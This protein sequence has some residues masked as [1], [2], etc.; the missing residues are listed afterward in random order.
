MDVKITEITPSPSGE[1]VFVKMRVS[2]GFSAGYAKGEIA[3]DFF[4]SLGLPT[5]I[6]E[7]I[8][9]DEEFYGR[10]EYAM[11]KT[12]AVKMGI[13]LLSFSQNTARSLSQKLTQRGV[14]KEIADDA[15]EYL[16]DC[17]YINEY[18]MA[19]ALIED[20]AKRRYFGKM[21]IKAD[22]FAK[23]FS[24]ETLSRAIEDADVDFTQA[25]VLRIKQMGGLN[26][27]ATKSDR[28]KAIPALRR[29]GFTVDEVRAAINIIENE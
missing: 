3:A 27:F 28:L 8:I 17:G 19:L 25:C 4:F 13:N 15:V 14:K 23:G 11:R 6:K 2:N 21:R 20:M 18:E 29:Y 22:L 10:I 1:E 9:I 5:E 16:K 26:I 7:P 12:D 24:G